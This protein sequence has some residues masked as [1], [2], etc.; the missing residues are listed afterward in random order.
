MTFVPLLLKQPPLTTD[1]SLESSV[2]IGESLPPESSHLLHL[3]DPSLP[4]QLS[5]QY[6]NGHNVHLQSAGNASAWAS[7]DIEEKPSIMNPFGAG[8]HLDRVAF[9]QLLRDTVVSKKRGTDAA[10]DDQGGDASSQHLVKGRVVHANKSPSGAW[11]I[12]TMLDPDTPSS[13]AGTESVFQASWIVDATGRKA[14]I[15]S[16]VIIYNGVKY[17]RTSDHFP[18]AQFFLVGRKDRQARS[19]PRILRHFFSLH[20]RPRP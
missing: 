2:Q 4:T 7:P 14:T 8:Y 16:K 18:N 6:A 19:S 17:R 10:S 20:I 11:E 13:A 1:L 3:L 15:A 5:N 9:D 12:M